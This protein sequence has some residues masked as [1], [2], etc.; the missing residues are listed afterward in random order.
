MVEPKKQKE[1]T[2][3]AK[4]KEEEEQEEKKAIEQSSYTYWV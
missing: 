3:I 2:K 4:T 1:D